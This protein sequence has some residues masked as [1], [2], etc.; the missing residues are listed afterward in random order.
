MGRMPVHPAIA[1]REVDAHQA[2]PARA[3]RAG[4]GIGLVDGAVGAAWLQAF[5][6]YVENP[7]RLLL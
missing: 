7:L 5:K 3:A 6:G 2:A 1:L 4:A